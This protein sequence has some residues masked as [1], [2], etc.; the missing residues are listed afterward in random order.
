MFDRALFIEMIRAAEGDI[1]AQKDALSQLDAGIGDG[2]HGTAMAAAMHGASGSMEKA[3]SF[4]QMLQ[5]MG[6]ASMAGAGGATSTLMGSLWL[7]MHT[8]LREPALESLNTGQ[9]AELFAAGLANVRKQT[10]AVA[11]DK[12]MLDALMPAVQALEE[13]QADTKSQFAAAAQAARAGA[14]A[15]VPM[16]A[17]QGRARN[18]GEKT[19]GH[20]DAGATSIALLFEAFARVCSQKKE[21]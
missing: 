11:G 21:I 16:Q 9:V 1:E 3:S 12:T 14:L 8:F 5:D 6:W 20:Q 18:L 2:D 4:A 10:K 17:K 19:I 7:G 13:N 15:T